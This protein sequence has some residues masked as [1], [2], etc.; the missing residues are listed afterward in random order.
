VQQ[1]EPFC[2]QLCREERNTCDVATRPVEA[3][4]ETR[5]NW[6]EADYKD[7]WDCRGCFFGREN[8][9]WADGGNHAD[10]TKNE[11]SR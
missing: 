11:I 3:A 6:V 4:D 10:L 5:L 8:G 7:D 2:D 1:F 9:T